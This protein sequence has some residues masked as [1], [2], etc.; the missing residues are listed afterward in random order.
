M[1]ERMERMERLNEYQEGE[2]MLN[3]HIMSSLM[4][5]KEDS[6][7]IQFLG[8][9]FDNFK[10]KIPKFES[11]FKAESDDESSSIE[12]TALIVKMFLAKSLKEGNPCSNE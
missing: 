5:F 4:N 8:K 10:A 6:N 1:L 12:K 3:S 9:S 2:K 7:D 11:I